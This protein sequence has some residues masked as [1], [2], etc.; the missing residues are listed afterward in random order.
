MTHMVHQQFDDK[1]VQAVMNDMIRSP[2]GPHVTP[3]CRGVRRWNNVIANSGCQAT[4]SIC[5]PEQATGFEPLKTFAAKDVATNLPE[6]RTHKPH[7]LNS[8]RETQ[9]VP[10]Q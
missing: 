7:Y 10:P 2:T 5:Q 3:T 1:I 9:F 8:T 4:R 6:A